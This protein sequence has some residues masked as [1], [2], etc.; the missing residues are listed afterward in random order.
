MQPAYVRE[1]CRA[2]SVSTTLHEF[3]GKC[4]RFKNINTKELYLGGIDLFIFCFLRWL[5]FVVFCFNFSDSPYSLLGPFRDLQKRTSSAVCDTDDLLRRAE[6]REDTKCIV[7][8]T[9]TSASCTPLKWSYRLNHRGIT[10]LIA[11]Y[12]C[13]YTMLLLILHHMLLRTASMAHRALPYF[14]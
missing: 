7:C 10:L 9:S 12:N 13:A 14:S 2:N 5:G 6:W 1:T 4:D 8:I 3:E 11:V